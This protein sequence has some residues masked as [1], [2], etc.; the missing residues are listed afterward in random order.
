MEAV[1]LLLV[2]NVFLV[3]A[4]CLLLSAQQ[5]KSLKKIIIIEFRQ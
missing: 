2:S 3:L 4:A 5:F 1:M